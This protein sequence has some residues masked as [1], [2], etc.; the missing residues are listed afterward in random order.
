MKH[1]FTCYLFLFWS[2]LANAFEYPAL[3]AVIGVA[4][5]D[6]LN[7]R[8][9]PD[10]SSAIV[11]ELAQNAV[12][13][14]ILEVSEDGKWGL[15]NVGERTG[16]AAMRFLA[17]E[18]D[19]AKVSQCFGTEPFWTANIG[20]DSMFEQAGEKKL[21]FGGMKETSS[22]NH[23]ERFSAIAEGLSGLM[24]ASIRVE[25]CNDGMSDRQFGLS[26]DF[27]IQTADGWDQYSGCCSI[28]K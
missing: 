22:L 5:N 16:W 6:V 26:A 13:I 7:V 19:E 8:D 1:I 15:M 9:E 10:A 27:L 28:K 21:R 18:L 24:I 3:H 25:Q 12:N 2:S 4:A 14:S 17:R 23:T 20:A 11:A